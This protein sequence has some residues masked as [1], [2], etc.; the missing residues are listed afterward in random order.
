MNHWQST[1]ESEVVPF[2]AYT[3]QVMLKRTKKGLHCCPGLTQGGTPLRVQDVEQLFG[4]DLLRGCE[5]NHLKEGRTTLQ[6]R[7]QVRAPPDM[8]SVAALI[9]GHRE[10]E[11]GRICAVECAVHKGLIQVQDLQVQQCSQSAPCHALKKP[12]LSKLP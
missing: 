11:V 3:Q 1:S 10:R 6:E 8:N 7:L 9:E 2:G 4:I 5:H 12:L